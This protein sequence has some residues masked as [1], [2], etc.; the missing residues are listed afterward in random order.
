MTLRSLLH[1]IN[2]AW[3]HLSFH[4]FRS[5]ILVLALGISAALPL[6]IQSLID[7]GE[8]ATMARADTTPLVVGAPGGGIDLVLGT[9]W[10]G[11]DA[12]HF[13]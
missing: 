7:R 8:T 12:V 3:R 13:V 5:L 4:G 2:L 1:A 10:F 6:V 9:L 11:I